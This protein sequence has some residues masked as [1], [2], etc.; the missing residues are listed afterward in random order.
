[1][2]ECDETPLVGRFWLA[3]NERSA[4]GRLSLD[5]GESPLLELDQPLT[6]SLQEVARHKGPGDSLT[7]QFVPVDEG[8]GYEALLLHGRL[9]DGSLLTL[10][11]AF[12][13]T[14]VWRSA[15]EDRQSLRARSAVV[16]A[17]V[18]GRDQTYARMR[19]RLRHQD[20]WVLRR[21]PAGGDSRCTPGHPD[22]DRFQSSS[23]PLAGGGHLGLVHAP[24]LEADDRDVARV[25]NA[26]WLELTELPPLTADLLDRR[27]VTPLAS[28]LTLA[29]GT[30]C[31]PV[32]FQVA[33]TVDE[34]WLSVH[35][36]GLR[37]D[38]EE[39]LPIVQEI[40]PMGAVGLVGVGQW[41]DRAPRLG[42]LP[43]VVA[44]A[45]AGASRSL[46]SQLLE[47]T[48]VAEGLHERLFPGE[49]N[50]PEEEA[51][52]ARRLVGEAVEDLDE[53]LRTAI[54]SRL[55]R[56]EDP[57]FSQRVEQLAD[58]VA[59]AA[60]GVTGKKNRWKGRVTTTRNEFAHRS[61]GFLGGDSHLRV[62]RNRRIASVVA[63]DGSDFR[64]AYRPRCWPLG[65]KNTSPTRSFA[66]RRTSGFRAFS[67]HPAGD[68]S[69]PSAVAP[70]A[71]TPDGR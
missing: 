37:R 2:H 52:A 22:V 16:G 24:E 43:P 14:R 10:E 38:A 57:S 26:F 49:V 67:P 4:R 19:L 59:T 56:L 31:P 44:A 62:S 46:E 12:T 15:G 13:T 32:D 61:Y 42:P 35:H 23:V 17:H 71:S 63:Y 36:S 50:F 53:R 60:P 29:T 21:L 54:A 47:L 7:R 65:S 27:F 40:L 11:D 48:T 58:S 69:S 28:L 66:G 34:P 45:A 41:L 9:D 51:D 8:P 70:F 30:D 39:V 1:M 25:G 55:E 33:I 3:G 6:P 68:D 5:R 18:D 64:P 20:A